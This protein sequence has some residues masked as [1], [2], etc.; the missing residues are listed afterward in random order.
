M[1]CEFSPEHYQDCLQLAKELGYS[2]GRVMDWCKPGERIRG[3]NPDGLMNE[4]RVL[5]IRHDIDFSLI[6][7]L[8]MATLESS[9]GIRSTY[10]IMLQSD[11]YN[12][13]SEL[14]IERIRDIEHMGHEIGYHLNS[15]HMI[16]GEDKI[17]S[18][19]TGK[20]IKTY[21]RHFPLVSP[22]LQLWRGVDA[23][24]IKVKYLS[25]S[26]RNWREDCLCQTLGRY[27]VMQV[28]IHPIW[29]ISETD[30]RESAMESLRKSMI[31]ENDYH[32]RQF[33]NQVGSYLEQ[34]QSLEQIQNLR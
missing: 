18:K 20:D 13:L 4:K 12:A 34:I 8:H 17:L 15:K 2:I 30:S 28:L 16:K 10:H 21:S 1:K 14:N 3:Y 22:R 33:K 6:Y 26:C 23:M 19:I 7:A 5:L 29:W 24:D 11:F 25:D 32:I 27:D 9:Q 31:A